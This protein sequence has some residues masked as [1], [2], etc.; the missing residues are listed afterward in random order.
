M[1]PLDGLKPRFGT[2]HP[3]VTSNPEVNVNAPTPTKTRRNIYMGQEYLD[4]EAIVVQERM[5]TGKD[6]SVADLI[7]KAC[8]EYVDGYWKHVAKTPGD[9]AGQA[10]D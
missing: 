5:R 6:I 9:P 10:P 2:N 1:R 7:R 3:P 8:R 4:M